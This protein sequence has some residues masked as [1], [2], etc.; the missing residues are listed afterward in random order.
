MITWYDLRLWIPEQRYSTGLPYYILHGLQPNSKSRSG[1]KTS[2]HKVETLTCIFE[3]DFGS[4][5]VTD[6]LSVMWPSAMNS[7]TEI[8]LRWSGLTL[9]STVLYK[10]VTHYRRDDDLMCLLALNSWAEVSILL[11]ISKKIWND[12]LVLLSITT[13]TI[14]NFKL[15]S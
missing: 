14:A 3:F 10:L 2:R 7:W 4:I 15:K 12:L 1:G 6:Y 8:L 13:W 9:C 5:M 11:L